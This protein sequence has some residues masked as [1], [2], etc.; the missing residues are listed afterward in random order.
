[1]QLHNV[2]RRFIEPLLQLDLF[3][4]GPLF[5][6]KR[7][8][9]LCLHVEQHVEADSQLTALVERLSQL[10]LE[11]FDLCVLFID[12]LI[13]GLSVGSVG[14]DHFLH[15]DL[16]C[17][18]KHAQLNLQL[19][20]FRVCLLRLLFLALS[21]LLLESDQVSVGF[22]SFCIELLVFLADHV[23]QLAD[24]SLE[25]LGYLGQ[26]G[27]VVSFGLV[28]LASV[29]LSFTVDCVVVLVG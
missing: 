10:V 25:G 17:L 7:L 11:L 5:S 15:L 8:F 23:F 1:L 4:S 2:G 13:L 26:V 6:S 22:L 21:G 18:D 27:L 3:L 16:M 24:S 28:Q 9:K 20:D 29:L 12:D 14:L 19:H